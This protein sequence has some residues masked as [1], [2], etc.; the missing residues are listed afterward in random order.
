MILWRIASDSRTYTATDLSGGGAANSP[1]RWNELG[2]K[3]TY[4]SL[5]LSLAV[6]ET[7][8]HIDD[9]GLPLNR[10]IIKI[11]VPDTVWGLVETLDIATLGPTWSSIPAGHASVTVGAA[12][13]RAAASPLLLVPSVIVP[14][15]RAVLINPAHPQSASI[16]ASV[17]RPFHYHSLF[18]SGR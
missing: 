8:A 12:W 2:Q 11:E 15:E 6:L 10:Y 4:A 14:E 9:G 5:T 3:V 1:G 18:R 16:T 7:A 13:I 17:H